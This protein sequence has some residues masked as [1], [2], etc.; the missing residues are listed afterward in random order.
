MNPKISDFGLARKF[1]GHDTS[2][3]TKKV[4]DTYGYISPDG[5]K[6]KEFS[7]GGHSDNLL[8]HAWRLYKEGRSIELTSGSLQASRMVS[9]V[10]RS[11][12]VALLCVQHHA[13]DR[14]TMLSV[15]LMLVSE[16]PLPEP[17]QPAFFSEES[18]RELKSLPSIDARTITLMYGR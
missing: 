3:K 7:H 2:A 1:V 13:E 10:L 5:K 11:I 14:P 4:V 17:K 6:N 12:H 9:E 16:G 15:V 18:N 8:G